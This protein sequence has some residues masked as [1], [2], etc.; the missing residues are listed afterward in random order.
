MYNQPT[1]KKIHIKIFLKKFLEAS[2]FGDKTKPSDSIKVKAMMFFY[3]LFNTF[4]QVKFQAIKATKSSKIRNDGEFI[5]ILSTTN[6]NQIN[7]I[8]TKL[9]LETDC[10]YS[11]LNEAS[12]LSSFDKKSQKNVLS[13]NMKIPGN[14][15]FDVNEF[16]DAKAQ[17]INLKKIILDTSFVYTNVPSK[18]NVKNLLKNTFFI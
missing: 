10:F 9:Y 17:D 3:I 1:I 6:K 15:F 4:P 8:I 5:L 14:L 18:I 7:Q 12:V 11:N 2:D 16:F 13:Y